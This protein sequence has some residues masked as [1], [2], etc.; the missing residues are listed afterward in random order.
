MRVQAEEMG[1]AVR[2]GLTEKKGFICVWSLAAEGS[3]ECTDSPG[4]CFV[5]GC[6]FAYVC[7]YTSKIEQLMYESRWTVEMDDVCFQVEF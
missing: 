1:S 6:L 4:L 2:W 3:A 7:V 5:N